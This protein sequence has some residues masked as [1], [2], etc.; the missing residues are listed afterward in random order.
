MGIVIYLLQYFYFDLPPTNYPDFSTPEAA[1][2]TSFYAVKH[3]DYEVSLE[4][5][6][7]EYRKKF[8]KTKEEQLDYLIESGKKIKYRKN[9]KR[10]II[11]VEYE[12]VENCAKVYYID[13]FGKRLNYKGWMPMIRVK[14]KW[15]VVDIKR[16]S[17]VKGSD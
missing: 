6:S 4:G 11:K 1:F 9:W 12:D 10:E 14:D 7:K 3:K 17:K 15:R 5:L 2:K 16:S 8:G 13:K